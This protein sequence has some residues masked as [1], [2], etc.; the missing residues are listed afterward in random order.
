MN[1]TTYRSP[2]EQQIQQPQVPS[3]QSPQL[4]VSDRRRLAIQEATAIYQRSP[5]WVTF[6][7]E[8]LGC[9]CRPSQAVASRGRTNIENRVSNSTRAAAGDLLVTQHAQ[10]KCIHQWISFVRLVKI[11]FSRNSRNAEA[12]PIMRDAA[13]HPG[14]QTTIVGNFSF[15]I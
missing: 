8:V 15:R 6:F 9:E 3:P 5:D 11:H 7:R 12:I 2:D 10:A 1:E 4:P 13:H 14:E